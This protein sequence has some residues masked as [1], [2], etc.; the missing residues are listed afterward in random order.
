M[1]WNGCTSKYKCFK[2]GVPQGSPLSPLLYCLANAL[3]PAK[4]ND[5][6]PTANSD[7]CADDLTVCVQGNT[8]QECAEKM[9]PALDA[10]AT[11]AED[12]QVEISAQKTQATVISLHPEET[13]GK[14][15]PYIQLNNNTIDYSAV[16]VLCVVRSNSVVVSPQRYWESPSTPNSV[17]TNKRKSR[18]GS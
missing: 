10:I 9:Q 5:A 6:S 16:I 7:Q 4:I 12:N 18:R 11:W 17:F 13:S 14:A 3:I 15:Q 8:P 2:E 1:R